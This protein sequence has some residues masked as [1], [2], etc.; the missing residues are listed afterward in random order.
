MLTE[1]GIRPRP[2]VNV[3][4]TGHDDVVDT[5]LHFGG[6]MVLWDGDGLVLKAV[7]P[8]RPRH[9]EPHLQRLD[10]T[11]ADP[12]SVQGELESGNR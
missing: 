11:R 9:L 4:D 1:D 12:H 10:E 8:V 2:G 3:P 5:E 7:E 6:L